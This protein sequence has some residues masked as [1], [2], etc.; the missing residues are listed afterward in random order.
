MNAEIFIIAETHNLATAVKCYLEG[1]CKRPP[2]CIAWTYGR[3]GIPG[4]R[5]RSADLLILSL[6]GRDDLGYRAEGLGTA[7]KMIAYRRRVL[8]ISGC[9]VA[10]RLACRYYWDLASSDSLCERVQMLLRTSPPEA[11]DYASIQDHF[12]EY[13]RPAV[14]RHR[15]LRSQS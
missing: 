10:D 13:I 2:E 4:D 12:R 7:E 15:M 14:D 3:D 1:A 11:S 5:F 9:A 6:F 8:L